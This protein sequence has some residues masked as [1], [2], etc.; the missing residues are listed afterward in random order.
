MTGTLYPLIL[1]ASFAPLLLGAELVVRGASSLAARLRIAPIVVGLTLV[2]F[3]TSLPEL[4]I[5]ISAAL[6]D[7]PAVAMGN[8]LGSNIFNIA[9]SIGILALIRA[10][11][12]TQRTT[13]AE[14]PIAFLA[15]IVLAALAPGAITRGEGIVLVSLF[16]LFLAY[17]AITMKAQGEEDPDADSGPLATNPELT[18]PE[19]RSKG[20]HSL[21]ATAVFILAGLA[22]L[23][24]GGE[25]V[26]RGAVGTARLVTVP[27]YVIAATIVAIGTSLPELALG[28]TA[29]R[30]G[31]IDLAV[32]NVVG[33]NIFNVFLVLGTT[34]IIRPIETAYRPIDQGFHVATTILLFLFVFTGRGRRIDRWEGAILVAVYGAY[35][36]SLVLFSR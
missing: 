35:S 9:A 1:V 2:A 25:G 10:L 28:I 20:A 7:L 14:I 18:N 29:V 3:G 13:W 15:A 36:V 34:A 31:E 5:N 24:L 12:I 4:V 30:R 6:R 22:L 16:V 21:P 11:P 23:A 33:S 26:V 27:E 32:G 8:V 17:I 19:M